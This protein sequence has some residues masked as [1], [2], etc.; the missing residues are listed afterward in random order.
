MKASATEIKT[1]FGHFLDVVQKGENVIIERSGKEL[2]T[3]LDYKEYLHLK[4]LDELLLVEKVKLAE[5]GGYLDKKKSEEF[6]KKMLGRL[7][8]ELEVGN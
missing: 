6:F 5:K 4:H 1:H 7:A 2:A 3:L 8:D